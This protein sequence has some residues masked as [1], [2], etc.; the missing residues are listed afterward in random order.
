VLERLTGVS[1]NEYIQKNIC[2]PL[3]LKNINM[4]P[5]QHMKDRLAYMHE[6]NSAGKLSPRDHITRGPLVAS[7]AE[8]KAACFQSGGAG[9]FAKPQEYARE[10][11]STLFDNVCC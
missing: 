11:S 1:L 5:T 10:Y 7:T 4:L 6:R 2:E 8:E 3:G 9:L